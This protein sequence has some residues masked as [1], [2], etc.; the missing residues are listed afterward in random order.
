MTARAGF[1]RLIALTT[2][3]V[4]LGTCRPALGDSKKRIAAE[5][6]FEQGTSLMT[7]GRYAEAC[8]KFE[9]SQALDAGIGTLLY[10]GDCYERSG[11]SA[12]AW[13]TFR[14]AESLARADAQ[15]ER[16]QIAATRAKALEHRLSRFA[17]VVPDEHRVPGL[18]VTLDGETVPAASYDDYL[19][20]DPGEHRVV[21]SAPGRQKFEKLVT[22]APKGPGRYRM[23]V[24][25]LEPVASAP[26]VETP[27]SGLRTAGLVTAG[28]GVLTIG[29]GAVLGVLA[30][31]KNEE[32]LEQCPNDPNRCTPEGVALRQEARE[33]ADWSTAG[34]A[35]G[36]GLL[37]TGAVLYVV[38]PGSPKEEKPRAAKLTELRVAPTIEPRRLGFTVKGRF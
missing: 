3:L 27:G 22:I 23:L 26:S 8:A 34:F 5:A 38:A 31:E 16:A 12:S 24:P 7:A 10:L 17:L 11:R 33:Y 21:V 36:G 15:T 19:P 1:T 4:A 35:A 20:I 9:A 32:S 30:S 2:W 29:A 13:A 37:V 6:L 28:A 14:E 18:S 25:E